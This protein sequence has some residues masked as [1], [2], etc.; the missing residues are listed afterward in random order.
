M[1]P[2]S[3]ASTSLS[4][5]PHAFY[6][7]QSTI[8]HSHEHGEEGKN[9]TT[10]GQGLLLA[11]RANPRCLRLLQPAIGLPVLLPLS[12]CPWPLYR[13][14]QSPGSSQLFL[15]RF[16]L[17]FPYSP[18]LQIALF[19]CVCSPSRHDPHSSSHPHPNAALASRSQLAA[20]ECI[21]TSWHN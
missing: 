6:P 15:F 1:S 2:T 17:T 16:N 18:F 10:L 8:H 21:I 5:L 20:T 12:L 13:P 7:H 19:I 9:S 4:V 3:G 11:L 14:Q